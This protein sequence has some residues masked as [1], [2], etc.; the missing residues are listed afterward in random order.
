MVY[1]ENR[2]PVAKLPLLSGEKSEV[3]WLVSRHLHHTPDHCAQI[4]SKC[5]ASAGMNVEE[6]G[7]LH[8]PEQLLCAADMDHNMISGEVLEKG[9]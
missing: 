8:T 3:N 1:E 6:V 4:H 9:K 2:E 7:E 5:S